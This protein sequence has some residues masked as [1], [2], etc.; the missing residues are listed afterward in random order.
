MTY[1]NPC[2]K[3]EVQP[4]EQ[5]H[6]KPYRRP[7]I[8]TFQKGRK[9]AIERLEALAFDPIKELV[10]QYRKLQVEISYQERLRSREVIEIT[11]AGKERAYYA[12]NHLAL[13][14]KLIKVGEALLPYNYGKVP[15]EMHISDSRRAPMIVN[16]TKQ[17]E[18]YKLNDI[19]EDEIGEN[20]VD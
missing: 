12:P 17:G 4:I 16:L 18:V 5:P 13:Y 14:D 6:L 7:D 3:K 1:Y 19:G 9:R 20:D 2:K 8:E 10:Q 15:A 11:P